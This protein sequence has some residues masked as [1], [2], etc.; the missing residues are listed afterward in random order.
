MAASLWGIDWG[1][2]GEWAGAIAVAFTIYLN[3]KDRREHR[4]ELMEE[5]QLTLEALE[6][7]RSGHLLEQQRWREDVTESTRWQAKLVT[8]ANN[9]SGRQGGFPTIAFVVRN[10]SAAS[11]FDV[12]P[13]VRYGSE[14]FRNAMQAELPTG[15]IAHLAVM[16]RHD[17]VLEAPASDRGATFRD[18]AGEYWVRFEHGNLVRLGQTPDEYFVYMAALEKIH[19]ELRE[20]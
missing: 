3:I 9:G 13:F 16:V 6:V 10:T 19:E 7:S 4:K 1:T 17:G 14:V 15:E 20:R 2:A 5:R 18:A 12:E 8:V 11:I